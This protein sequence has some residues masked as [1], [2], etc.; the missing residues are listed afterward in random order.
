MRKTYVYFMR[1]AGPWRRVS[2]R[3]FV[4]TARRVRRMVALGAAEDC[5]GVAF[6]KQADPLW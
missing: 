1:M 6:A 2:R 4:G 3:E 5:E